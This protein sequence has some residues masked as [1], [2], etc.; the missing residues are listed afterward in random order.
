MLNR[1]VPVCPPNPMTPLGRKRANFISNPSSNSSFPI[2][3]LIDWHQ[4]YHL[5]DKELH[6]LPTCQKLAGER[7][8]KGPGPPVLS[9]CGLGTRAFS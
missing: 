5:L 7:T 9:P 8:V 3:R 6:Q 2:S 1:N 4:G